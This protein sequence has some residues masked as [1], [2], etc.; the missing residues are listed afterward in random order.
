VAQIHALLFLSHKLLPED[1]I[2]ETLNVAWSGVSTSIR[3]V[4]RWG[5]LVSRAGLQPMGFQEPIVLLTSVHS[6]HSG[7]ATALIPAAG[8]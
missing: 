1:E 4:E 8:F 7:F 5:D 6:Q 2:A 3:K